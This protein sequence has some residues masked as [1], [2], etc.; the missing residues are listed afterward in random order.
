MRHLDLARVNLL[1]RGEPLQE[2]ELTRLLAAAPQQ[3]RELLDTEGYFNAR[4]RV[5]RR[6]V[7]VT[8][9]SAGTRAAPVVKVAVDLGP[10]TR[11]RRV[12]IDIGGA[13]ARQSGVSRH[14]SDA[15][16]ALRRDWPLPAGAPFRQA[17]W[18]LAKTASIA[19]LRAQGY[20]LADWSN[21]LARVD[22]ATQQADLAVSV[23]SGELF[24]IGPLRVRGLKVHDERTVANIADLRPGEPATEATVLDIQERLQQSNLFDRITVSLDSSPAVPHATPVVV[25]LGERALQEATVGVGFGANVGARFT[26]SHVHR[27]PFGQPWLARNDF[28]IAELRRRWVGELSTHTLPGLYRNLVGGG[29]ERLRSDSDEVD[30]INLRVGRAQDTRNISRL[31]FVDWNRSTAASALGRSQS[32]AVSMQYHGIWRSLDDL[33]L[34]TDGR[35]WTGQFGVGHAQ[36]D[37]GGRGPG[38]APEERTS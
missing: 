30:A 34:P 5:E 29:L 21:T 8:D 12:N 22:A 13:L 26:L 6:E 28:D 20:L 2:G 9:A 1:A 32:D 36:S 31:L 33:V 16:V 37:P 24:L 23:D 15:A 18:T 4:V 19:T 11:V 27:R 25:R 38:L 7:D 14:V 3:A 35:A 10:R 17:E